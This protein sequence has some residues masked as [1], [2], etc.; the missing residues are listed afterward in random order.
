[1]AAE[2]HGRKTV[3]G[4]AG[5]PQLR[6]KLRIVSNVVLV[7]KTVIAYR[8]FV[9]AT[10]VDR[11]CVGDANLWTT[12]NLTFDGID[13]LT[14]EWQERAAIIPVIPV[15]VIP[16]KGAPDLLLRCENVIDFGGVCV[17]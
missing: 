1:M 11:P 16:R 13:R 7:L 9:H 2:L 10:A 12:H 3:V 15:S 4:N 14:G 5:D 8:K 6:C 17:P